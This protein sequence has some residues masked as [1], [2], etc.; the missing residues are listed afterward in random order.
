MN[1]NLTYIRQRL[2]NTFKPLICIVK[3]ESAFHINHVNKLTGH[4]YY[5]IYIVSTSFE[6]KNRLMRHRLI[7]ACLND[8]MQCNIH[9]LT[10]RAI[11]PSEK[12]EISKKI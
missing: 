11:T 4:E 12:F 8:M 9:A 5:N 1:N 7:Y 2:F 10:I 3:D 6:K